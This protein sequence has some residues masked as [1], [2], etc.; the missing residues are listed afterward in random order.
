MNG[1]CEVVDMAGDELVLGCYFEFHLQNIEREGRAIIEQEASRL[2]GRD[3]RLR[4]TQIE[5][6][7]ARGTRKPKGGHLIEAAKA[8]GG[9]PVEED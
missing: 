7:A 4:L 9:R 3:V 2:L 1:S 5:R 8:A 6:K